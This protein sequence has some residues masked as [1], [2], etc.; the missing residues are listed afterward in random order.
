MCNIFIH[1]DEKCIEFRNT[2]NLSEILYT[3]S[4][5]PHKPGR[6]C[7]VE[8]YFLVYQDQSK[9]PCDIH[10]LDCNEAKPKLLREKSFTTSLLYLYD[11]IGVKN[12]TDE[13]I[14]GIHPEIGI[15]CYSTTTKSLKWKMTGKL[16]GTKNASEAR[17]VTTDGRGHLFVSDGVNRCIQM[18]SVSDGQYLDV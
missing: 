2:N 18:F 9:E 11:M 4:V 5:V 6:L 14:I 3:H 13:L 1:R 8:S 15:H 10:W 7:T 17:K 16:L 12:G